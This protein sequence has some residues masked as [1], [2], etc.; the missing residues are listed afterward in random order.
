[1]FSYIVWGFIFIFSLICIVNAL[2]IGVMVLSKTLRKSRFHWLL[3]SLSVSDFLSGLALGTRVISGRIKFPVVCIMSEFFIYSA[4]LLSLI[5]TA[6]IC[7]ERL[8]AT[9]VHP[10]KW[11]QK[12]TSKIAILI[13]MIACI[14]IGASLGAYMVVKTD[15]RNAKSC[16]VTAYALS[17]FADIPLLAACIVIIASYCIVIKRMGNRL[18]KIQPRNIAKGCST[19]LKPNVPISK[20]FGCSS[21]SHAIPKNDISS[22]H[23]SE[24]YNRSKKN[25]KIKTELCPQ[26]LEL[27]SVTESTD[28]NV[29]DQ[30]Q[31]IKR[32]CDEVEMT[33]QDSDHATNKVSEEEKK[34]DEQEI[35]KITSITST[36]QSSD[37]REYST[38]NTDDDHQNR[39]QIS[40]NAEVFLRQE[41]IVEKKE[42][43]KQ[44]RFRRNMFTL[45]VVIVITCIAIIPK[46]F[47]TILMAISP[48]S[49]SGSG[50]VYLKGF[51]L[52]NPIL[53]PFVYVFRIK[54]FREKLNLRKLCH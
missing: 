52:I 25:D 2:C 34:R 24:P 36:D 27:K 18:K 26:K 15:A 30:N 33:R 6:I 51:L 14:T 29:S 3:L 41:K 12:V 21:N 23:H 16:E 4:I 50:I 22:T 49:V 31:L 19:I 20:V 11:I 5:G 44:K 10:K 39:R 47:I 7:L 43:E 17:L 42:Q 28:N 37:V 35:N 1:M 9:F 38:Q 13:A 40:T 54:E 53:D 32:D 45:G 8:N 46:C 48:S